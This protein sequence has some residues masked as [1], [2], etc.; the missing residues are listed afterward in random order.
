MSDL[1]ALYSDSSNEPLT[2]RS[3]PYVL[4]VFVSGLLVGAVLAAVVSWLLASLPYLHDPAAARGCLEILLFPFADPVVG[5]TGLFRVPASMATDNGAGV[6]LT[7]PFAFL[8][9]LPITVAY[10]VLL[11]AVVASSVH[12]ARR[13]VNGRRQGRA[14]AAGA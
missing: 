11:A 3:R 1:D 8:L 14:G 6:L 2:T 10:G 5:A 13:I 4:A 9:A 7:L 12:V